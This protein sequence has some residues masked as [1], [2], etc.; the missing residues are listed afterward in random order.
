MRRMRAE[1][2]FRWH[3][4]MH[5]IDSE[6]ELLRTTAYP[7]KPLGPWDVEP[8]RASRVVDLDQRTR[9]MRGERGRARK[10]DSTAPSSAAENQRLEAQLRDSD[11]RFQVLSEHAPVGI[12]ETD[13]EGNCTFVNEK[14]CSLAGMPAEAARGR[15][16][17]DAVHPADRQKVFDEW[18]AA[19]ETG[20]EFAGEYRFRTPD[21]RTSWL[22]GSARALRRDDG[23]I[24]GYIG[25]VT[26]I[27]DHIM[28][29]QAS[30][31]LAHKLHLVADAL[32]ALISYVDASA[33]YRF[34]NRAYVDWFGHARE[35]FQGK[36]MQE[37]LGEEAFTRVQPYV[38]AALSG[39]RIQYEAQVP[40]KTGGTRFIQADYVPHMLADG[41]VTGFYALITD[42]TQRKEAEQHTQMLLREVNHRAKNLLAVVQA[43]A[44][45][46]AQDEPPAMFA[47]RFSARLV[48]LGASQDL[49]VESD[50]RGV[51]LDSLV[52]SQLTHLGDLVK[53]RVALVGKPLCVLPAASQ[54]LGLALHELA[55]NAARCGALSVPEGRVRIMW[56]LTGEHPAQRFVMLWT[57]H[58]GPKVEQQPNRAGFGHIVITGAVERGLDADVQLDYEQDGVAWRVN[59][60]SSAVVVT[61]QF[62]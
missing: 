58:G 11:Q 52:R 55:T 21:G 62:K 50:W 2:S 33:H 17:V 1:R 12:F 4:T 32:P 5:A 54:T 7:N 53:D 39:Q 29:E 61:Q 13:A 18:Y 38:E 37:V 9:T 31:D 56:S 6:F 35:E 44:R 28:S 24:N 36:H 60:P 22:K 27:T 42:I 48:A 19:A 47:E 46:T 59:A 16:W 30:A 25:T 14:W 41:S 51:D 57:E 34:N 26:D 45:Q 23:Q 15:G 10:G 40:Y 49:L 20:R 3:S 43:I 8:T